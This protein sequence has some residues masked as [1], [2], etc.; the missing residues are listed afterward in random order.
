VGFER[1]ALFHEP[2]GCPENWASCPEETFLKAL[3]L[4]IEDYV[5]PFPTKV[6]VCWKERLLRLAPYLDK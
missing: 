4:S 3:R 5:E 2:N 6:G 1:F